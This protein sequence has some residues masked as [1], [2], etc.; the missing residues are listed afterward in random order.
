MI[1]LKRKRGGTT[2]KIRFE[3]IAPEEQE[4]IVVRSQ[5]I[6]KE[7]ENILKSLE[8]NTPVVVVGY[9]ENSLYRIPVKQILYFESID[10][11]TFLYCEKTVYETKYKLYELENSLSQYGF[12]RVSKSMIVNLKMI[13]NVSPEFSGRF[14]AVLKNGETV[15]IS[16]KYVPV[17]K[18]KFGV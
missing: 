9:K 1:I 10:N 13:H 5:Q 12:F 4:E 15:L 8:G 11:R 6:T 17:M 7:I 18:K 14:R 16:R 2:L 3:K